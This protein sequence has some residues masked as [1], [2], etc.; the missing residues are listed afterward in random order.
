MSSEA[1]APTDLTASP[2][3]PPSPSSTNAPIEAV[4]LVEPLEPPTK[5]AR[6][7]WWKS[8]PSADQPK[9]HAAPVLTTTVASS[10]NTSA[11]AI[12]L[13]AAAS[14]STP[15]SGSAPASAP[16]STSRAVVSR[17]LT[18]NVVASLNGE[19]NSFCRCQQPACC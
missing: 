4:E 3:K 13:A 5:V 15:T 12:A 2:I 17:R 11:T 9:Q 14:A 6:T 10:R 7:A 1:P 19:A 16:A 18:S 8:K